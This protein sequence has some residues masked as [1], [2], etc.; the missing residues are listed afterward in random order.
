VKLSVP[1]VYAACRTLANGRVRT[2]FYHRATG[3]RLP[4]DPTCTAFLEQVALLNR[5]I[6]QDPAGARASA[7][8]LLG[9][10]A[11]AEPM[12][13]PLHGA[14][15][16]APTPSPASPS[17]EVDSRPAKPT[18]PAKGD[19][20]PQLPDGCFKLLFQRYKAS[21]EFTDLAENTKKEYARHMRHVEPALGF[22]PVS[23]FSA[24]LMDR[25]IAKFGANPTLQR[26][27]RRTMSVLLGYAM[28]ILKWIRSN[29]LLGVQKVG[30]RGRQ[31]AGVRMPLSEPA[32][33]RFRAVNP[34]GSRARLIFEL[35]LSTALRRED[36]ARVRAEDV[37]AGEI[38]L[39]TGKAGII[40]VAAVTKH[41]VDAMRAFRA[42]HPEHADAFYALGAQNN[43]QPLHKRTISREFEAAAMAAKFTKHERLHALRYTAATRLFELGLHYD[44]IAEVTGHAM[45]AMARHYC[46]RRRGA[47]ER[48]EMLAVFGDEQYR[49]Q[50]PA[51][52]A[53]A[54]DGVCSDADDACPAKPAPPDGAASGSHRSGGAGATQSGDSSVARGVAVL[55]P[56]PNGQLSHR[57]RRS[58]SP[59]DALPFAG[60][61]GAAWLE[62]RQREEPS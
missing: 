13:A 60:R 43:G 34:Y 29:P 41:L 46:K 45:A 26:A 61:R 21:T 9:G 28:R 27:I 35:A 10:L 16:T 42:H 4:D 2:Y 11:T 56:M 22:H 48:G 24:D 54:E 38:P 47:G 3:I 62:A 31:A 23:A 57:R 40:I 12:A 51:A 52:A 14:S 25:L 53:E 6:E 59:P 15:F 49:P 44:D 8:K 19:V 55:V 18:K 39:R 50:A 30:R 7:R 5:L 33:A 32:V 37:E 20:K 17:V 36:L 1:G 58:P